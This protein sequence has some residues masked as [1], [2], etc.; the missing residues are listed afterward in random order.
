[1]DRPVATH[2]DH[3]VDSAGE[4][5]LGC[6]PG[7]IAGARRH[8]D[9]RP[10]PLPGEP[11]RQFLEQPRPALQ[12]RRRVADEKQAFETRIQRTVRISSLACAVRVASRPSMRR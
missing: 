7:G 3:R 12:P 8:V 1:V 2:R 5:C 6:G 10:E 11:A 4:N 9:F